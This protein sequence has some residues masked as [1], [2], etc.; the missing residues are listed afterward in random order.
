MKRIHIERKIAH[1]QKVLSRHYP[2]QNMPPIIYIERDTDG[3]LIVPTTDK[4]GHSVVRWNT[5]E[6]LPLEHNGAL[7]FEPVELEPELTDIPEDEINQREEEQKLLYEKLAQ[8]ELDKLVKK[9]PR[10]KK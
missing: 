2:T 6:S 3:N 8:I 7:N 1:L 4:M 9:K 5:G 10:V